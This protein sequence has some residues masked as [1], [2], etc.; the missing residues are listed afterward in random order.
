VYVSALYLGLFISTCVLCAPCILRSL[1]LFADPRVDRRHAT[2]P[3]IA[4]RRIRALARRAPARLGT[5]RGGGAAR[6]RDG[7]GGTVWGMSH[8]VLLRI[9][10]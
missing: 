10:R 8:A 9:V 3:D 4:P 6:R 2:L 1:A 7:H 5:E